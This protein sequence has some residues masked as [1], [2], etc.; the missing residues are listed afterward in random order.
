[1]VC[2]LLPL[3]V[4]A[5]ATEQ[6]KADSLSLKK[7]Q[8]VQVV[9]TRATRHAPMAYSTLSKDDIKDINFGKDIPFLLSLSPSVLTTSDAGMGIGYTSLRVRG[10][11]ASRINTTINGVPL[12]DAESNTTYWAKYSRFCFVLEQYSAAKRR[13]NVYKWSRCFWCH[14]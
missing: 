1:M 8:E 5:N 2:G 6:E 10:T 11:D 4:V 9:S 14:C 7:L 3:A 12:N 13:R